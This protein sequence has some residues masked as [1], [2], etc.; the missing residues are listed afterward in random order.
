MAARIGLFLGLTGYFSVLS[1]I[2][3]S[4]FL[5]SARCAAKRRPAFAEP[6]RL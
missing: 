6:A 3:R 5:S 2:G 4:R 1:E